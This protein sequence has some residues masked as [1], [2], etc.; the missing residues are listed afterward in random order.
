[1]K[2]LEKA[3][4]ARRLSMAISRESQSLPSPPFQ[5]SHSGST[6]K[7]HSKRH[8][9]KKKIYSPDQT[10]TLEIFVLG[11]RFFNSQTIARSV[12]KRDAAA[13]HHVLI[14]VFDTSQGKKIIERRGR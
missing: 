13:S 9:I 14:P 10:S 5:S 2:I 4:L 11:Y 7:V 12:S 3:C 8:Q 1:M 6:T